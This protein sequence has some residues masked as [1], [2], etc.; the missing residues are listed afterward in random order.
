MATNLFSFGTL[1]DADLLQLVCGHDTSSI[2]REPAVVSDYVPLWVRDDHYPVLVARP[3][4][5]TSGIILRNLSPQ[6]LDR[7]VFFEGGEFTVQQIDVTSASGIVERVPYF[8]DNVH[9]GVSDVVWR[10]EHWQQTTKPDTLPRVERYM[11]CYGKMSVDEAD[12]YW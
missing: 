4:A 9:Q 8:A 11:Q 6:A 5:N 12:A 7:I 3:G 2:V 10:L 1:M